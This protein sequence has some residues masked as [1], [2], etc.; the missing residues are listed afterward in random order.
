MKLTACR[1][2]LRP[3]RPVETFDLACSLVRVNAGAV[4]RL[5][6]LIT[7]G[8]WPL[9]ELV[10]VLAGG[11]WAGLLLLVLFLPLLQAPF[12][13]LAG[14]LMFEPSP[15]A[16][17]VWQE[18]RAR[19]WEVGALVGLWWGVLVGSACSAGTLAVPCLFVF[20]FVP[21]TLLLDRIDLRRAVRRAVIVMSE[22]I[23]GAIQGFCLSVGAWLWTVAVA[24]AFGQ[25]IVAGML[26]LGQPFGSLLEGDV[27]PFALL[28]FLWGQ[29]FTAVFRVLLYVD[30]RS[31]VEGWDLHY[32]L[33]ALAA[34]R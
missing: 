29:A 23:G 32:A 24:E 8:A 28:G 30:F 31:R 21:E 11:R 14:R 25:A 15:R 19:V 22:H 27:T 18:L 9:A 5:L 12:T 2:A 3:R 1:V 13:L 34:S 10:G 26:Q 4:F 33:R 7:A 17:T 16:G 20:L 6:A